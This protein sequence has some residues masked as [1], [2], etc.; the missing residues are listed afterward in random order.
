MLLQN[1]FLWQAIAFGLFIFIIKEEWF[2]DGLLIPRHFD[3]GMTLFQDECVLYLRQ[4]V[5]Y[6]FK[7]IGSQTVSGSTQRIYVLSAVFQLFIIGFKLVEGNLNCLKPVKGR[8]S[9][10]L[11]QLLHSPKAYHWS[12]AGNFIDNQL[13]SIICARCCN[14]CIMKMVVMVGLCFTN[15]EISHV[16]LLKL[17][18]FQGY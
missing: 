4:D 9:S 17:L 2:W 16:K 13:A 1:H 12:L 10:P 18:Y 11:L 3:N 15:T 5:E 6:P 7:N 8:C 14:I